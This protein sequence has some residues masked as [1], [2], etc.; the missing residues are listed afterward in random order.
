MGRVKILDYDDI[1]QKVLIEVKKG[2][3]IDK[4]CIKIGITRKCV[5]RIFTPEQK[6]QIKECKVLLSKSFRL[7]LGNNLHKLDSIV[8]EN[9][10]F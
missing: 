4:A 6:R 7:N 1:F 5:Y 8:R 10:I 3:S 9:D 2:N